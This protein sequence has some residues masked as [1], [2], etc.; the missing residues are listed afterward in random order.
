MMEIVM[1]NQKQQRDKLGK[2]LTKVKDEG[3]LCGQ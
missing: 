1:D 3:N 2:V